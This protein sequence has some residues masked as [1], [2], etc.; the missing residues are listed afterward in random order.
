MVLQSDV[1]AQAD[2]V[3]FATW[4]VFEHLEHVNACN[5]YN[6]YSYKNLYFLQIWGYIRR[7]RGEGIF[8]PCFWYK[9]SH[10]VEHIPRNLEIYLIVNDEA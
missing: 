7:W 10:S 3:F 5:I 2:K 9:Y 8:D 6:V 4:L 1:G